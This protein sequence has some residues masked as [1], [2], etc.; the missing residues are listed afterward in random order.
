MRADMGKVL[1]DEP[2]HGRACARAVA[3]ARRQGR[4]RLDRDG[5]SAPVRLPMKADPFACKA[6][7]EHL[8]PLYRF[9]R[10]QVNRPWAKVYGE[11]CAALDK[12]SVVQAHLFQ[13]IR[14][15]VDVE[16]MWRDDGVWVRNWRGLVPLAQS[17]AD[18][19]VHPRTGI[20]LVNRARVIAGR[21]KQ[22]ARTDQAA[23]R[24][25]GRRTDVKPLAP[26]AQWHRVDGIWYAVK[27][28]PIDASAQGV[29]VY[30]VLLKRAVTA[31]THDLLAARYGSA[32]VYAVE[33]RQLDSRTLRR[34]GLAHEGVV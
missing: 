11:L 24:E 5:E 25:Q 9:L 33:K 18:L 29:P 15:K 20:L 22:Q 26:D 10:Q 8:G 32:A 19:Y 31:E 3:G 34:H 1:V 28:R 23:A 14:D 12:R 4:N 13:H 16:A 27:L 17:G 30:D 7:G 21:K 6:F 2:R